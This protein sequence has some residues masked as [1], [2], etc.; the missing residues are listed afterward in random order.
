M[1]NMAEN[2]KDETAQSERPWLA[3]YPAG[4]MWDVDTQAYA[5]V[6]EVLEEAFQKFAG[7]PAQENLG[8]EMSYAELERQSRQLAAFFQA[9][10]LVPGDTLAI[11]MPNVLQYLVHRRRDG[12]I[13][14]SDDSSGTM[15]G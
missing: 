11:Q 9:K 13:F 15:R 2:V 6:L 1:R 3:H 8:Y 7:A 12:I 10:G 5:N 4:M 14:P